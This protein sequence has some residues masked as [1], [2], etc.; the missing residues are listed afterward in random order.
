MAALPHHEV[1]LKA[2][3]ISALLA[4][5]IVAASHLHHAQPLRSLPSPQSLKTFQSPHLA[6]EA[7][8]GISHIVVN[9]V[10]MG[11][12]DK[13]EAQFDVATVATNVN[14]PY[15]ETSPPGV[16]PKIG[17]SVDGLFSNDN[18]ATSV[19]QPAFVAQPYTHSVREGAE[20]LVPNGPQTWMVRFA[21][22]K[23]G[24]WQFK[25]RVRDAGGETTSNSSSFNVAATSSNVY[26][27]H[28]F[29]RVSPNDKRYFEF[30]DG[31]PFVGVGFDSAFTGDTTS[32]DTRLTK[33][34]QNKINFLRVWLSVAGINGTHWTS[35]AYHN[36]PINYL[37]QPSLDLA[38]TFNGTDVSLRLDNTVKCLFTDFWQG[39]V[40]ALPNTDYTMSARVK[41]NGVTGSGDY[42]FVMKQGGWMPATCATSTGTRILGPQTG[43][44]DWITLTGNYKTG[45]GQYWLDNLYLTLQNTT[46]GQAFVDEVRVWRTA[47]PNKTNV[48]RE[49]NANAHLYFDPMNA[50]VWDSYLELAEKHGV[51]VK[52]V[53]DEKNEWIRTHISAAGT[54]TTTESS[55]NFYAAAN[56]KVR[57]L[58]EAW[59]RYVIARWGY[60]TAIHSFELMNEG[61]PY[62][63]DHYEVANAFAKYVHANDPARHLVT[64]SFW[65]SFPGNEFWANAKYPDVDYADLHA[66]IN[67]GW[68]S[69]ATFLDAPHLETDVGKTRNGSNGAAKIVATNHDSIAIVPRGLAIRGQGEWTVRYWLKMSDFAATCGFGS[70]GSMARV[71]WRVDGGTYNGGTQGVVPSTQDGRSFFCT[72]PAG[73]L[74]WKQFDSNH[75]RDGNAVPVAQRLVLTDTKTHAISIGLENSSGTGGTAWIDDMELV[76]PNGEASKVIGSFD[77]TAMDEDTAWYN[78]A[79]GEVHGGRSIVGAGMPLVRGEAGIDTDPANIWPLD[80]NKD[81]DGVWLHNNVWGQINPGGMYDLFWWANETIDRNGVS[82]VGPLYNNFLTYRNFM[83]GIPLSNG[84]Y[85][86]A[87]ATTSSP[88]LRAWGQ[89]DDVNGRMHL[90]VQN[91]QHT[92]KRVVSG[93]AISAVNGTITLPN[94]NGEYTVEWWDTKTATNPVLKT[95][96]VT[97]SGSLVLTLPSA[98]S[99]DVGV[100]IVKKGSGGVPPTPTPPPPELPVHV[101]LPGVMR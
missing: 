1:Y 70:T 41:L 36:Q 27:Q 44:T 96:T 87:G 86:D 45:D 15:A 97:A 37:P 23:A 61:D 25:L 24:A 32:L 67:S 85:K 52:L 90:W 49:P 22:Q 30:G 81:K 7:A 68:G 18:F 3:F 28:G 101:Y 100:K 39:N 55:N 33:Y 54:T 65:H 74:D 91:M 19:V 93:R 94:V 53:I 35:W 89:R 92:W 13:F 62:N 88:D 73:N 43:S 59:W 46:G 14:F 82:G 6:P 11:V 98:L 47:D 63:G 80:L 64:T 71:I 34:E 26:R 8:P 9:T 95:E 42:G 51:Y 72:S 31:S 2:I 12:Y 17:V 99:D 56:T 79:Y 16:A 4:S 21:P 75:D 29:L 78:R 76:A 48:L 83:A 84:N 60:S 66:Y 57:F 5:N 69:N 77:M 40:P 10:S 50:A 38:T 58:L 20:H